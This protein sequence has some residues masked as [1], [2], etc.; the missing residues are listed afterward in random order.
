MA[1]VDDVAHVIGGIE[2]DPFVNR[3]AFEE[4]AIGILYKLC[5][6][7]G[8]VASFDEHIARGVSLHI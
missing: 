6:K 4:F 8:T 3:I 5:R 2:T 7:T 1:D